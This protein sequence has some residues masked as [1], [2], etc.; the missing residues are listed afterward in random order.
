MLQTIRQKKKKSLK[1][2]SKLITLGTK[3][4][5]NQLKEVKMVIPEEGK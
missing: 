5:F 1:Q 2:Q 3:G 4:K